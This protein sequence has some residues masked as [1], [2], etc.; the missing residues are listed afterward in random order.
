VTIPRAGGRASAFSMFP[1]ARP[2]FAAG[3]GPK[4]ECQAAQNQVPLMQHAL[5]TVAAGALIAIAILIVGR[6]EIGVVPGQVYRLDRWT[7]AVVVCGALDPEGSNMAM[8]EPGN[9]VACSR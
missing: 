8:F 7:G 1:G 3:Q 2:R 6:W 4:V 9:N 5:A